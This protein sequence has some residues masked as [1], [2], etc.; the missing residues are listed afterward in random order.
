M[1]NRVQGVFASDELSGQFFK[2]YDKI[3][4]T[5]KYS[6]TMPWPSFNVNNLMGATFNNFIYSSSSMKEFPE[7]LAITMGKP[8]VIKA[9]NGASITSKSL[10]EELSKRGALNTF[11]NIETGSGGVAKKILESKPIRGYAIDLPN[12]IEKVVRTQLALDVYKKTGS[13]DK[14]AQAVWEVHGNY[15]PEF[16]S[17]FEKNVMARVFPFWRWMRTSIPFQFEQL[18]KQTGKYAALGKIENT[19][20]PSEERANMPDYLK[21]KIVVGKSAGPDGKTNYRTADLPVLD[22]GKAMSPVDLASGIS[23]A[24]KIPTELTFNRQLFTGQDIVDKNL[25]PE[26]QTSKVNNPLVTLPIIKNILGVKD[27]VKENRQTGEMVPQQEINSKLQYLLQN[28]GPLGSLSSMAKRTQRELEK[29]GVEAPMAQKMAAYI[30]G[31][32]SPVKVYNVDTKEAQYNQL[33]EMNSRLQDIINYGIPRG[34]IER[35]K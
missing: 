7:A 10:L 28:A 35:K 9:A 17:G 3:L 18:Y 34:M 27:T 8:Q 31:G 4:N 5:F 32:I 6:V 26:L 11:T 22:I 20:V 12:N 25:P 30:L 33:L 2:L 14:A 16:L 19:I 21:N 1:I 23:P 29:Q 13:V 24:I 15:T